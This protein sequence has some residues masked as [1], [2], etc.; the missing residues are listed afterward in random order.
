MRKS[1]K[2]KARAN[3]LWVFPLT[4]GG[5]SNCTIEV[6]RCLTP[7]YDMER[8]GMLLVA[9]VKHADV[10]LVTGSCNRQSID[11]VKRIYEQAPKPCF[12]V[13]IGQCTVARGIFNSSYNCPQPLDKALPVDV[14]IPVCPPTPE[15]IITALLKLKETRGTT[16]DPRRS[17]EE[18]AVQV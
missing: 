10:L 12:V 2:M 6:L 16:H 4:T 17:C 18:T 15:A 13:A 9:S 14:Y 11:R 8:H 5:C 7:R 1:L 3:S